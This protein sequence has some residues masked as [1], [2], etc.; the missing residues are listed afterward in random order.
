[1]LKRNFPKV[2]KELILQQHTTKRLIDKSFYVKD[3]FLY[4]KIKKLK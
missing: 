4:L 1:M 2:K 3:N